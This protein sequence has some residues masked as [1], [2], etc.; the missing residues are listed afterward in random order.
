MLIV[1]QII[2]DVTLLDNEDLGKELL[3][4][5]SEE[6]KQHKKQHI[7]VHQVVKLDRYNYTVILNLCEM[8]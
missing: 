4:I 8:N 2:Y 5:L 3:D 1:D 6:K 7:I